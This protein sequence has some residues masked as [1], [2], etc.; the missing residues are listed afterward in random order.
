MYQYADMIEYLRGKMVQLA[1]VH[2]SLTHRDVIAVSQRLDSFILYV[3]K[4]RTGV[5]TEANRQLDDKCM[6]ETVARVQLAWG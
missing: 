5:A 2:G 3:Q 6:S 4:Q 1:E